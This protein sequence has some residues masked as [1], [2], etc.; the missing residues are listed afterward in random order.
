[1]LGDLPDL[2]AAR[3]VFIDVAFAIA[4]SPRTQPDA[5]EIGDA[6][7]GAF[8]DAQLLRCSLATKNVS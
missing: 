8:A 6:I 5:R 7:D 4:N 2:K 1:M 3:E